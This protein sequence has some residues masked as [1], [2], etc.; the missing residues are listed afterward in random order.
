MQNSI[1][2]G[3]VKDLR[4]SVF[5]LISNLTSV[6]FISVSEVFLFCQPSQQLKQGFLYIR[7]LCPLFPCT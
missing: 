5:N 6:Y 1:V 4:G 7:T 2:G 3:S